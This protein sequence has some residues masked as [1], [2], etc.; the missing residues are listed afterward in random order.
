MD[1]LTMTQA[2]SVL[3]RNYV[4][5]GVL[6]LR[7]KIIA[8]DAVKT[9][10][11]DG[12]SL[13]FNPTYF[14]GLTLDERLFGLAHEVLH[15]ALLHFARRGNRNHDLWNRACDYAINLILK[16]AGFVLPAGVLL[17]E[18]FR[19]LGAEAIYAKLE[20]ERKSDSASGQQN[21]PNSAGNPSAGAGQP[22]GASASASPGAGLP[23]S[24]TPAN[25]NGSPSGLTATIARPSA[26]FSHRL[27]WALYGYAWLNRRSGS[28]AAPERA[29]EGG[30]MTV[31]GQ[32]IG[33]A[34]PGRSQPSWA[35]GESAQGTT[36]RT[37]T[38]RG[39][40]PGWPA[41]VTNA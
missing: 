13:F 9:L 2:R 17:D 5:F 26:T 23:N 6:A 12:V 28:P 35:R 33:A 10:A 25:G 31:G 1:T 32:Y 3:V 15:C 11:V 34:A 38:D 21:Q 18:R 40:I 24:G 27:R 8:D 36:W 7:L 41:P 4:W 14:D 19:G 39:G 30:P 37:A 20:N 16:D 29:A 22:G